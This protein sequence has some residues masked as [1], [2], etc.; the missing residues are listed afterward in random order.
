MKYIIIFIS[1]LL[2]LSIFFGMNYNQCFTFM[3]DVVQKTVGSVGKILGYIGLGNSNNI[4]ML[5]LVN[6]YLGSVV[7]EGKQTDVAQLI[8]DHFVMSGIYNVFTEDEIKINVSPYLYE[9]N[10]SF[11]NLSIPNFL[12]DKVYNDSLQFPNAIKIQMVVNSDTVNVTQ[13]YYVCKGFIN[14]RIWTKYSNLMNPM[15]TDIKTGDG[16]YF[17]CDNGQFF[18]SLRECDAP[19]D[20]LLLGEGLFKEDGLDKLKIGSSVNTG[21]RVAD[22]ILEFIEKE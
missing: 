3:G 19:M 8:Y 11:N 9:V 14:R 12:L 7:Y 21:V 20:I 4:T 15:S 10:L 6:G 17:L 18:Y 5:P 2:V 13:E 1:I 22:K 16:V